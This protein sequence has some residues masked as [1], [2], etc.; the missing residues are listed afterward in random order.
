MLDIETR[1]FSRIK[2]KYPARLKTMF[3]NTNFTTSDRVADDPQFPTIY[4]HEMSSVEKGNDL[5][6]TTI[7]AVLSTFQIEVYDNESMDN[8]RI[9]MNNVVET[10]KSMGFSIVSMPEFKNSQSVYRR[11]AR[12]RRMIGSGDTL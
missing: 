4:V 1:V 8:A 2:N 5:E 3:P 9:V 6:N 7:N 12:F 10:M 11:V